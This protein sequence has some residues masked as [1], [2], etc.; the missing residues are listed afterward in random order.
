MLQTFIIIM[1]EKIAQ[2][3]LA[4][5]SAVQVYH[6]CKMC[7]TSANYTSLFCIVIGW[8]KIGNLLRQV[9]WWQKFCAK[10]LRKCFLEWE[11]MP[12]R[13]I[14]R[15]FLYSNFFMAILL[16]WVFFLFNLELFALLSFKKAG[17]AL[18]KV[19]CAISAFWKTHSHK[20]NE[21]KQYD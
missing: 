19:A 4:E 16:M 11:K 18:A 1:R 13:K 3:W 5:S 6:L 20:L 15:H 7:N 2:F 8:K 10:G 17:I 21:K 9:K 12:P 14:L